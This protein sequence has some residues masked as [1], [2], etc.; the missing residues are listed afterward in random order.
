MSI[1]FGGHQ[2]I[3]PR[4]L[5]RSSSFAR[6][7]AHLWAGRAN[8]FR[9]TVG[10]TPGIGWILLTYDQL[11]ALDLDDLHT[12]TFR[13]Y[14]GSFDLRNLLVVSA[15]TVTATKIGAPSAY[16]LQLADVRHLARMVPVNQGFNVR[17]PA[18]AQNYYADTMNGGIVYTWQT[19]L[20]HLWNL[21][22]GPG[23]STPAAQLGT[24]PTLPA[25]V[26]GTPENFRFH[27]VSAWEAYNEV[28]TQLGL[29]FAY[30]PIALTPSLVQA[31]A[32]DASHGEDVLRRA[33]VRIDNYDPWES[34]V[35]KV[36]ETFRVYFHTERDQYGT[37]KSTGW[38]PGEQD[39]VAPLYEIDTDTNIAGAVVGTVASVIDDVP[40]RLGFERIEPLNIAELRARAAERTADYLRAVRGVGAATNM[41]YAGFLSDDGLLPGSQVSGVAWLDTGRGWW[42]ETIY[43]PNAHRRYPELAAL[44]TAGWKGAAQAPFNERLQTPDLARPGFPVYPPLVQPLLVLSSTPVPDAP[45]TYRARVLRINVETP[46]QPTPQEREN[47]L[48][49]L[50]DSSATVADGDVVLARLNGHFQSQGQQYPLYLLGKTGGGGGGAFFPAII[51]GNACPGFDFGWDEAEPVLPWAGNW[52]VK[53]GG[54]NSDSNGRAYHLNRKQLVA[55]GTMVWMTSV[56][57]NQWVFNSPAG[58]TGTKLQMVDWQCVNRVPQVRREYFEWWNGELQKQPC[59]SQV[60][61]CSAC[62]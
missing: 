6:K 46:A 17:A 32:E 43:L 3:D 51:R 29:V 50:A 39:S 41:Q 38:A 16:V 33:A 57:T 14:E 56:G 52:Q 25:A 4:A 42:T 60:G 47:C 40:A 7:N 24:S 22:A 44:P 34:D 48:L 13:D 62:P 30:D 18:A 1:T 28:L 10:A 58:W 19:L 26:S 12:L 49:W 21:F 54:R 15:V 37:E 35:G 61:P 23:G 5:W 11:N 31:G 20:D 2:C 27:G 9:T 59:P 45:R 55:A 8:S 36:A 53:P